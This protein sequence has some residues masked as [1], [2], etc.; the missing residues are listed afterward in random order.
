MRILAFPGARRRDSLN[1][2]L[3]ALAARSAPRAGASV[4]LAELREFD[5][6]LYDGD[7]ELASGVPAGA[8]ELA[9]RLGAADGFLIASPE[10]NFGTPGV[11]KNLIDWTSRLKPSPW[12]G[13][14]GCLLSA[15]PSLVGGNRGLWSTRVSLEVL[16]AVVHPDMFSLSQAHQA[17]DESG[18]LKDAALAK[19]LEANLESYLSLLRA[20]TAGAR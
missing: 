17:F 14:I 20:L 13:K 1:R 16:S 8:Q 19:R 2:K 7:D 9:R 15:S 6:P 11:L 5:V 3:V 10:Y 12:R 18:N 4:D